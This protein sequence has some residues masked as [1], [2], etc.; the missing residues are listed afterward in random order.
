MLEPAW[1]WG[2]WHPHPDVWALC[3]LLGALYFG[4]LRLVG[5]HHVAA[6]Q[7][8]AT[9]AQ[10][11][12]FLVAIG[13][14]LVSAEWPMHDLAEG[15]LYSAHMVQHIILTLGVAPMLL[16]AAPPWMVRALLPSRSMQV[17]RFLARPMIALALFNVLIVFTHWPKV[18][19]ATVGSEWLHLTVHA[20]LVLSAMVMWAPV[21]SPVMEIPRLSYPGQMMYL[22]LQSL[23]PTVP[24]SFL[25]FGAR[26][27]YAVYERFPHPFGISTLGDQR[28]AGLIMK[29]GG[30]AVLWVVITAVF[31]KWRRQEESSGID[32]LAMRDVAS[33]LNRMELTKR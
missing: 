16:A 23:V 7:P 6:G 1:R 20:V 10:K 25:T 11:R 12:N 30:G 18:V 21:L 27:L 17:A 14:L 32:A 33:S 22:F 26:P 9:G 19:T 4:M 3:L 15:Y 5:P 29:I 2:S 24:A 31:F 28:A 13:L 8:V